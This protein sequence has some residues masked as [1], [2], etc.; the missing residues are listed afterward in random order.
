MLV[1]NF[2]EV[3]KAD[4]KPS[5]SKKAC[6]VAVK[7]LKN[8]SDKVAKKEMIREFAVMATMAHPNIVHLFGV[9]LEDDANPWIVI[10]YFP[11]GDLK[12]Y[13]MVNCYI[14][15]SSLV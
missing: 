1:G 11:Y 12:S 6:E 4:Y 5:G 13:L 7:T 14:R 2:G 3:F 15:I 9:V 8:D 10:E